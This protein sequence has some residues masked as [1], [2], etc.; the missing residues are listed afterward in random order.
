MR[1]VSFQGLQLSQ[2]QRRQL[3]FQQQARQA[4][5]NSQLAQQVEQIERA[6]AQRREEGAK[7]ERVWTVE[8]NSRGTPWLGDVFG[9][10][11]N[12]LMGNSASSTSG[13]RPH[14]QE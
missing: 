9:F 1:T 7:P 10:A 14:T 3:A 8:T 6:V 13:D 11:E 12:P 2:A 4:F 5:M